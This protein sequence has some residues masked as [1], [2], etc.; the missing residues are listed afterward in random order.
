M[1]N[2]PRQRTLPGCVFHNP[3]AHGFACN[4]DN[5]RDVQPNTMGD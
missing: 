4:G 5:L 3:G 1:D 2:H